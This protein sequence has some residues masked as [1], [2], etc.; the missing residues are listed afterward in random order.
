NDRLAHLTGYQPIFGGQGI[1]VDV[2]DAQ[3]PL[4]AFGKVAEAARED[5]R[6]VA[7]AAQL[8]DQGF[9]AFGQAQGLADFLQHAFR[10][11]LE[12]RHALTEAGLEVQLAA[13]RPFG[14]LRYLG[15]DPGRL[16][17]LV[18]HLGVDQGGIHVKHHQPPIAAE[19]AVLLEGDIHVQL[20][21]DGQELGPQRRWISGLAPYGKLDA[22]LALIG[23]HAL[24]DALGQPIDI[25]DV[26]AVAGGDFTDPSDM[27]SG[28]PPRQ[29]GNDMPRLTLPGDPPAV[30]FGADWREA[31]LLVQFVTAEQNV[32]E[33]VRK[34]VL[35]RH[36]N[37]NTE[38]QS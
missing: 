2:V 32:L 12:Q 35:P 30:L 19:D 16:G 1:G 21:R 13:H 15:A 8:R 11:A 36:F 37:E 4:Q 23:G 29:Q 17:Q 10:Q 5:R 22:A 18:D 25:V 26:Q 20:L 24:R 31:Y 9:G 34:T 3:A 7:Q 38:R 6:L 28:H 14:N 27:F 33:Y